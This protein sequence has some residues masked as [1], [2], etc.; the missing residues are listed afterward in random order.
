MYIICEVNPELIKDFKHEG[1]KGTIFMGVESII[2]MYRVRFSVVQYIQG[3]YGT[4]R[5]LIESL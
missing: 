2:R 1:K 3:N 4:G 5:F